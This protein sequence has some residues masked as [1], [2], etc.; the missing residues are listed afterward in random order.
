MNKKQKRERAARIRHQQEARTRELR[1][2][3]S[4]GKVEIDESDL[5]DEWYEELEFK[6]K[7]KAVRAHLAFLVLSWG[8]FGVLSVQD[9]EHWSR[10][11]LLSVPLVLLTTHLSWWAYRG[12]K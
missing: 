8:M 4:Y 11:L 12:G 5:F 3:S 7:K 10:W 2:C 1:T 9:V 6:R